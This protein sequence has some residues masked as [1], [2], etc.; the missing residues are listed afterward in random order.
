MRKSTSL[1]SVDSPHATEPKTLTL[2]APFRAAILRISSR[3]PET[4]P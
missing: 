2:Q 1:L 4:S 3:F